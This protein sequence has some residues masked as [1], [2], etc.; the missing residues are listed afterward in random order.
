MALS[1]LCI[2][3]GC[4]PADVT[5]LMNFQPHPAPLSINPVQGNPLKLSI[6]EP[7]PHTQLGYKPAAEI[8]YLHIHAQ[9]KDKNMD[10]KG[11]RDKSPCSPTSS[12][13]TAWQSQITSASH[14]YHPV[15]PD[16][17]KGHKCGRNQRGR[18]WPGRSLMPTALWVL[19][20]KPSWEK[21]KRR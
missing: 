13:S 19:E 4:S 11:G 20:S 7:D 17:V 10:L 21:I 12:P 14:F 15:P 16:S 1:F 5:S 6:Q 9:Y 3:P 18:L 2:K 8:H